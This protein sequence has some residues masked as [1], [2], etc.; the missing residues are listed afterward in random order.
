MTR[1]KVKI[2]Y[3]HIWQVL[4]KRPFATVQ[5]REPITCPSCGAV[6]DSPFCPECGCAYKKHQKTSF[7][8]D[9][10]SSIPFLNDDAKRTFTHLLLRPGYMMRDYINGRNSSYLA[11]LTA[12]I[13]FYAFLALISSVAAPYTPDNDSRKN[14]VWI[15]ESFGQVASA[16]DS[17]DVSRKIGEK[18]SGIGN[19]I[20]KAYI[21]LHL[22]TLPEEVDTRL[23]QS[24]ASVES[25]LRSQGVPRFLSDLILM[26]LSIWLVHRK[27]YKMSFSASAATASYLLCQVCFFM[28]FALLVSLGKNE[29]IDGIL[30]AVLMLVDFRQLFGIS[31]GK[32]FWQTIKVLLMQL[33][34]NALV[35]FTALCAIL[36]L[37]ASSLL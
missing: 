12:L 34:I 25:T 7:F 31:W 33:A 14:L 18:I 13:I 5:K 2:R 29:D 16:Q 20:S 19:T 22:D 1:L 23:E 3:F 30:M 24:V 10:F 37:A 21:W 35:I 15:Q 28:Y 6:Y 8:K 26:T 36:V 17:T 11:P 4:G 27:K 32:S 9:S